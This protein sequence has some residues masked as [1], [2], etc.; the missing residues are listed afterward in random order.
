[1][2]IYR[3]NTKVSGAGSWFLPENQWS[4]WQTI[5]KTASW[6]QWANPSGGDVQ[7]STQ[8]NNI[9][10]SWMKIRA[11]TEWDYESL[12]VY[13][14][15]TVYLTVSWAATPWQPW[16]NTIAYYEFDNDLTDSSG[17]SRDLTLATW[18][19]TYGT[20]S[21]WGK[22]AY[23]DTSTYTTSTSWFP[24]IDFDNDSY[25]VSYYW[26]P[27]IIYTSWFYSV[28]DWSISG[29]DPRWIRVT[30]S[31]NVWW[32]SSRYPAVINTWYYITIVRE[33]ANC[34]YYVNGTLVDS[35]VI[36]WT[37]QSWSHTPLLQI[38]SIWSNSNY[39]NNNYLGEFIIEDKARTATEISN[40]FNQTKSDYWIS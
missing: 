36:T 32:F 27:K 5:V 1:M 29:S 17:N 12:G 28:F 8:A 18:S 35:T 10:Q 14:N 23:F 31:F 16:V 15:N 20:A 11:W 25:T 3:W 26:Q 39:V 6:Y 40:Y 21:W 38:N 34:S 9:L 2:T 7:V 4:V 24:T 13:D 19:V 22:Y 33:W 30:N 37:W